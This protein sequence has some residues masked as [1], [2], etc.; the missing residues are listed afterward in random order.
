MASV[1]QRTM[2]ELLVAE[3]EAIT[4]FDTSGNDKPLRSIQHEIG[5]IM[6]GKREDLSIES[7]MQTMEKTQEKQ[8]EMFNKDHGARIACCIASEKTGVGS[9]RKIEMGAM[10]TLNKFS[11]RMEEEDESDDDAMIED[12]EAWDECSSVPIKNT[13]KNGSSFDTILK[14]HQKEGV[15][16]L[17]SRADSNTGA[18]LAF[19]MGLGKTLT[20]IAALAKLK[21]PEDHPIGVAR[22]VII[23]PASVVNG[24][25]KE[26]ATYEKI[27]N[28]PCH[29]PVF[30]T[31]DFKERM[32]AWMT[33]GGMLIMSFDMLITLSDSKKLKMFHNTMV[34]S[35]DA[36]I[37]DEMHLVKN[38][39]TKRAK[40][41]NAFNTKI[42]FGLTGTPLANSPSDWFNIVS[43]VDDVILN[44][45]SVSDFK[46]HFAT[47]IQKGQ[48]FDASDEVR[49]HGRDQTAVLR[50]L[51]GPT[52]LHKSAAILREVLPVKTEYMVVYKI[53]DETKG[54]IDTLT[55]SSSY[56]Q[57][58]TIVDREARDIKIN[59]ALVILDSLGEDDAVLVFS[60]HPATLHKLNSYLAGSGRVL[61]GNTSAQDR[62]VMINEFESG[63]FNIFCITTGAGSTGINCQRANIVIMLDPR[64]NPTDDTQ[65]IHRAWRLGQTKPVNVYRFAGEG[66][67]DMRV[68]RRGAIKTCMSQSL[69][70]SQHVDHQ[71]TKADAKADAATTKIQ[72]EQYNLCSD[73]YIRKM[74]DIA[75][76]TLYDAFFADAEDDATDQSIAQNK[77]HKRRNQNK[78]TV[79]DTQGVEHTLKMSEV[80]LQDSNGT[81]VLEMPI[82][83]VDCRPDKTIIDLGVDRQK[84]LEF[85]VCFKQSIPFAEWS[86]PS[87]CIWQRKLTKRKRPEDDHSDFVCRS[88]AVYSK[89]IVGPWS[90]PSAVFV[91]R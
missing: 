20:T 66:T 88:R 38:M 80:I 37:V 49:Q 28:Y 30:C 22:I 81:Q 48:Y 46:K 6:A 56:L 75:G 65:A 90:K 2:E 62:T 8:I 69:V 12:I 89:T 67:V 82:P 86:E 26:H 84:Q 59:Q 25:K 24:W 76:W 33:T 54:K 63:E 36:L 14:D 50:T 16:F 29:E 57:A 41:I 58:Q 52:V 79:I 53:D 73:A 4:L 78:R 61:E 64:E 1:T 87:S 19:S 43:L 17:M 27:I 7:A 31:G 47:P 44:S 42:R 85:Q 34:K 45:L 71:L 68:L 39:Q 77:Y 72:L 15:S 70:S 18:I 60:T 55:A 5:L 91:L 40:T 9:K 3:Q 32:A 51:L 23:C 11:K 35:A 74:K 21:I 10:K 13:L 83:I